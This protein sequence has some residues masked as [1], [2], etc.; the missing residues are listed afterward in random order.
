MKGQYQH[1]PSMCSL[2]CGS[3]GLK[4]LEKRMEGA[5]NGQTQVASQVYFE[6]M[7]HVFFVL[8]IFW[9]LEVCLHHYKKKNYDN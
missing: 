9:Q 6:R 1:L 4:E 3:K 2:M 7:E 8:N 5:V